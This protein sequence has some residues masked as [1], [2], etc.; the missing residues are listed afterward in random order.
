MNA[1]D[2][3]L[4]VSL[5]PAMFYEMI[6]IFISRFSVDFELRRRDISTYMHRLERE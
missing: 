2:A 1:I 4:T 5:S 3:I 6:I